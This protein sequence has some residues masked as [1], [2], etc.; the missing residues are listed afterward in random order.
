MET[1]GLKLAFS[2]YSHAF[3]VPKICEPLFGSWDDREQHLRELSRHAPFIAH[4]ESLDT[5]LTNEETHEQLL[6]DLFVH[7]CSS[8]NCEAH[9][10]PYRRK[11]AAFSAL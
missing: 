6:R 1:H 3:S 5:P 8:Y 4:L 9:I 2:R 11:H 10:Q 7:A